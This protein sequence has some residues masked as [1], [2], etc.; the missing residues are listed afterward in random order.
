MDLAKNQTPTGRVSPLSSTAKPLIKA[1]R[2]ERQVRPPFWLMRQAG[3]YLPEYQ[4]V[5][6]RTRTFLEFC[7]SPE[8][9]AEVTLQPVRRFGMDGANHPFSDI[10]V[11]PDA[12][13]TSVGF[14]AGRGPVLRHRDHRELGDRPGRSARYLHRLQAISCARGCHRKGY[15]LP[16]PDVPQRWRGQPQSR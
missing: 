14:E 8:L 7:Y 15:R 4:A 16:G 12:L 5:R 13:G 9:A 11:I 3:R 1:L 2:G 6:A 10:L